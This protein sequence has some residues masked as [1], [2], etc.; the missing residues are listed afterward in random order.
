MRE[1]L[2]ALTGL[3]ALAA[4]AVVLFHLNEAVFPA[5]D[6]PRYVPAVACFYLG[7][8]LFFILSGF[9]LMHVHG[10][11]FRTLAPPAITRFLGLRLARIYPVHLAIMLCFLVL[12][13][14]V[15]HL[16]ASVPIT[17]DWEE[18]YTLG[19]F[20]RH[21]FLVEWFNL[22]WNFPA[23][24]VGAE[25]T[26]YLAF[27]LLAFLL[28]RIRGGR[29]YVV[30]LLGILAL[31]AAVYVLV[32]GYTLDELC[33]W[34]ICFEFP[35]GC[36]LYR[37][38]RNAAVASRQWVP[39]ALLGAA[40]TGAVLA[41]GTAWRDLAVVVLLWSIVWACGDRRGNIVSR[42]LEARPLLW[43]GEISYSVYMVQAL[44][45]GTVGRVL[46]ALQPHLPMP[47]RYA[48]VPFAVGCVIIAGAVVHAWI[49][50]PAR[51]AL[52]RRLLL[53]PRRAVP[54]ALQPAEQA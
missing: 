35:A 43:L 42:C 51:N 6:L 15:A 11:D 1:R 40:V 16:P 33:L 36:L 31:Y 53:A 12:V 29:S 28:R 45:Q 48:L 20:F 38:S 41:F 39:L 25:W 26:A 46:A 47:M 13:A 2:D 23:W 21:I 49:E 17:I 19:G 22:T 37:L 7:V 34:R 8:D 50:R 10:E 30:L 4:L 32:L 52:R 54:G 44:V 24:S 18:R 5:L 27:P 14:V 9:V 3:R